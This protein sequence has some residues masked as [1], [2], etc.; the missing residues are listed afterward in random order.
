[1][2][3]FFCPSCWRE[4]GQDEKTCPSCRTDIPNVLESRT[5]VEKL[6]AALSHREP[7]TPI[8]AASIL[9]S[10]KAEAAVEPLL[11]L[12]RGESDPYTKAAAVE[13]LGQIGDLSARTTLAELAERGPVL[14]RRK[15]AEALERL[16]AQ[17]GSSANGRCRRSGVNA[18]LTGQLTVVADIVRQFG[19]TSLH[20]T[21]RAC[22]VLSGDDPID[23]AVLGQFKSGKS[24]LLNTV[25][26]EAVFPVG[27]VPVTAVV[28]RTAA[29]PERVVRVT[30][31]NGAVEEVAP[32]RLAEF[33]TEAGNPGNRQQVAVVDVFTP[34]MRDWPG[35]R[36][37]DTPGLGSVLVHNTEATRSWMP[38]VAVALVTVS[39]ERPLSEEDRRLVGEARQTAPRV[40]VLLT[41]VDLLMGAEFEEVATFL[42]R[43]LQESFRDTVPVLPFSSRVEPERYASQLR[44]AVLGPVARNVAG[45]KR[46]ALALKLLTLARACQGYLAVGLQAAERSDADRSRIRAAVLD[47]SVNAALIQDELRLAEQRVCA[48]TRQALE[49]MFFA[50]LGNLAQRVT[51]TLAADLRTWR[52]NLPRQSSQY[53][54]WMAEHLTC[55]LTPLSRA[56]IPQGADLLRQAEGRFRR[57]VEAFRDR[58]SRNI[59]EATS[60][61]VSPV[62]W[63]VK[64]P[65][66]AVVPVAVSRVF[67]TNWELLWWVLPMWL[68]GGLFRRH[69]LGLV[70]WEVEKNLYRLAGDWVGAVEAAVVDLRTQAS[71]WVDAELATLD[72]LL[73]KQPAEATAFREA[74]RR[75]GETAVLQLT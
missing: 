52:G 35:V 32:A 8:R 20:A 58:L 24:S 16:R 43:A 3:T 41:K 38:N 59:H 5:Y 9:G 30:Y 73:G 29:G 51:Q 66:I 21:V 37:V 72:R 74:I 45:E 67:M 19:L 18:E 28:T 23:V 62:A 64:W 10:L 27:A 33:V 34:A 50:E 7:S 65:Q 11:Q 70:Y 1:M 55:E 63:E 68:V 69:V 75:L 25:L 2:T 36:L 12:L 6:I 71:T 57:V 17:D 14:L 46:A 42:D 54:T 53:E 15:A 4:V 13:A 49:K 22:E 39:A 26:G 31:L 56:A 47:E 48:G 40:V 44:E 61:T 60:V